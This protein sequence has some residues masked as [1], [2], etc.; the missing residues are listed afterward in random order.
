MNDKNTPST[1]DRP[2]DEMPADRPA[3]AIA[4]LL[5]AMFV[6]TA[7]DGVAKGLAGQG[8]PPER[9]IL[10]RYLLVS[11]ILLPV[12][13]ARWKHRPLRTTRPILHIVRG[14]L[15]IGSATL[16]VYAMR[17]LPLET[18]TAIGFVSPLYVTALSIPFLGEKVGVRRWAAVGVGFVGVLVILR[19]GTE[20]FV[21]AMLIPLFSSLCWAVGLIITR[22]MR[23]REGPLTILV[24]STASGMIVIAPLGVAGWEMPTPIQWGMLVAIA[25]C[26][27]AG[28]YFTIRAFMMASASLLAPFSYSTIIW[29]TLI[30]M[31]AFGSYPDIG[32]IA[33]TCLL[34]G[35]GLYVW[36]RERQVTGQPTVPGGSISEVA[37]E[38][39]ESVEVAAAADG[40]EGPGTRDR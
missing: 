26:H 16:F 34:A 11:A 29:A 28:Q 22:A 19:P 9:I 35:A 7:M 30:G 31:F 5:F 37:Q 10:L 39:P 40:S 21:L 6:F 2:A 1:A 15:L 8:M 25:A 14:V 36:H 12:V 17:T 27:A 38:A 20:S 18:A 24:W 23:G 33:G 13:L 4:M 32:T 3:L